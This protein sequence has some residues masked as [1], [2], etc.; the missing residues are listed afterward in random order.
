M[1]ALIMGDNGLNVDAQVKATCDILESSDVL[2]PAE[3]TLEDQL[4]RKS[5]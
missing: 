2:T 1:L 4:D 5:T 3:A